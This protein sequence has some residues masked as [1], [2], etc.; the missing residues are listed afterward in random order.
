MKNLID[1]NKIDKE[2]VELVKFFNTNGFITEFSCE[3]HPGERSEFFII[4]SDD[5]SDEM[6]Y[7]FIYKFPTAMGDFMKW[8]RSAGINKPLQSNWMY[9][10]TNNIPKINHEWAK[11]DLETFEEKGKGI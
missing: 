5:V 4:F 10:I 6:M 8:V 3:G 1:Y 11:I 9:L 7:K 2:C